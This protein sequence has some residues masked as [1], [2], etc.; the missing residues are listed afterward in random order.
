M[1]KNTS[2]SNNAM[3][4]PRLLI[5]FGIILVIIGVLWTFVGKY[6]PIGRLPGDIVIEKQNFKFYFPIVTSILLSI[7]LTMIFWFIQYFRKP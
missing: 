5:T 4:F 7:I 2:Y 1:Y 3:S 6:I